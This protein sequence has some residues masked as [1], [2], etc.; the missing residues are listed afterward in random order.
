MLIAAFLKAT[1]AYKET[2]GFNTKQAFAPRI[3]V[4][5]AAT[6]EQAVLPEAPPVAAA[7]PPPAA[8]GS[9]FGWAW[10]RS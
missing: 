4:N 5:A 1:V 2:P 3:Q 6:D 10:S 9:R 8:P 7:L